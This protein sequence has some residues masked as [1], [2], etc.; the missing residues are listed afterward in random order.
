MNL[1]FSFRLSGEVHTASLGCIQELKTVQSVINP[2][3]DITFT[4]FVPITRHVGTK[5]LTALRI[6]TETLQRRNNGLCVQKAGTKTSRAD[7]TCLQ[8]IPHGKITIANYQSPSRC[9]FHRLPKCFTLLLARERERQRERERERGARERGRGEPARGERKE[10]RE[11]KPACPRRR[12]FAGTRGE[13]RKENPGRPQEKKEEEG[14]R[15]KEE[16][17]KPDRRKRK[18]P[19][20]A[21]KKLPVSNPKTHTKT[22]TQNQTKTSPS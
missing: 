13:E 2:G 18:N 3:E 21:K 4:P 14:G 5:D 15:R 12:W 16:W 9:I 6:I 20:T 7:D 1:R 19:K 8:G 11:C 10:K 17:P 22:H